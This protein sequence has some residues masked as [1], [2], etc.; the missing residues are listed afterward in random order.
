MDGGQV[1]STPRSR[2]YELAILGGAAGLVLFV[3]LTGRQVGGSVVTHV[4]RI[5]ILV[6]FWL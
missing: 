5:F 3:L 2:V 1:I 4:V 6:G